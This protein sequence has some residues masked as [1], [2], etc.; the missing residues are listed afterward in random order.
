MVTLTP[1]VK[2]RIISKFGDRVNIIADKGVLLINIVPRSPASLAGLRPGDVVR[3]INNQPV[4]TI[5]DVQ[6]LVENSKIG[7]PL[8][9]Q[10]ERNGQTVPIAVIPAPLPVQRQM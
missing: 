3:S 9:I 4:T 8:Q 5:E 7:S 1:E 6:K 2:A 10:V